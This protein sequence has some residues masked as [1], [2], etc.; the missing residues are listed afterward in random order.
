MP[1]LH[2]SCAKYGD[3]KYLFDIIINETTMSIKKGQLYT[4]QY[5]K[6]VNRFPLHFHNM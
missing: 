5:Y 4:V 2:E 6:T 1:S 3:I